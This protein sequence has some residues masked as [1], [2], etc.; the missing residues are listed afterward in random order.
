MSS[1]PLYKWTDVHCHLNMLETPTDELCRLASQQG[2]HRLINIGT[3]PDDH[4]VCFQLSQ[5]HAPQMFCAL[6]VHPHEAKLYTPAVEK[7]MAQHFSNPRC[8]AVGEIGL[9]Y[10]YEH[11]PRTVQQQVFRQQMQLAHTHKLPVQIHTR[12]AEDDTAEV[13]REFKGRVQGLL[14]C[15]TSSIQL[16]RQALECGFN[17]SF[18]GVVTFKNAEALREVVKFVPLDRMHIETD[19]PF[20]TPVP[21]RGQKNQPAHMLHTAHRVAELKD[22]SMAKLSQHTEQNAQTLFT[23][24]KNI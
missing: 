24:L 7:H 15:F 3:G 20:L 14:H 4:D 8:V 22:V 10:Y 11:S 16:A 18:S 1:E 6:G 17:I 23:K 19:S 9:D 2:V 13:L 12:E 21:L 5:H